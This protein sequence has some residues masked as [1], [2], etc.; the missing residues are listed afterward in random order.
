[1]AGAWRYLSSLRLAIILLIFIILLSIIGTLIPQG[2]NPDFYRQYLPGLAGLIR[3]LQFDHLYRSPLFLSLVFLFLLNLFFCS[4]QQLPARWKRLRA[5]SDEKL[6]YAAGQ[7]DKKSDLKLSEWLENNLLQLV[8]LFRQHGYRVRL[9]QQAEKKSFLA[10]KGLLGLFGPELV[11]LGLIIIIAGGLVSAIFSQRL[12]LAL[13][14]GQQEQVGNHNFSL[15]LDRFTTEYYPDGSVKDWKS[16]VS[17]VENG[18]IRRQQ[19]IEVNHPLKYDRWRIFQVSYGQDWDRAWLELEVSLGNNPARTIQARIGEV[20][21]LPN[22]LQLRA[23]SFLPDFQ[24]DASGQAYSRSLE[25]VNPAALLEITEEG[26]AVFSGWVF[27][28]YPELKHYRR[29]S[30][31]D[32]EIRLKDFEAPPF[33]VLEVSSDPGFGLVWLGSALLVL[34]LLAAFYFPYREVL[35]VQRAGQPPVF[36]L[37]ARKNQESFRQEIKNLLGLKNKKE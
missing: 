2:Q 5:G 6:A 27:H 32:L 30:R 22:G 16:Q 17:V 29:Q 14:E 1:M 23:L 33:S 24:L 8:S 13:V 34:G 21:N 12:T 4:V 35:L 7:L 11:H 25:P 3:F 28:R 36:L 37:Y 20:L 10:R 18:Q 19:V 26:R 31:N 9:E 15:R